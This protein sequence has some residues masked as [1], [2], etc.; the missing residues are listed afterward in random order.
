MSSTVQRIPAVIV[1]GG[2]A[3]IA[4]AAC[5]KRR[6]LDPVVLEKGDTVAPAWRRHYERLHLHTTRR[7]SGLP[8]RPM[9]ADYPKYPSRDQVFAYL[10]RYAREEGLEVRTGVEVARCHRDDGHWVVETTYGDRFEAPHLVIATGLSDVPRVPG[11][12]NQAAYTGEILHSAEYRNGGPY[13]GRRVLVVGFGNSAAEIALDLFEHGAS[14]HVSVR[15][16]TV[17]V[18]RDVAGIIPVLSLG[19]FLS[20]LPPRLADRL[21]RPLRRITVGDISKL[22]IPAADWGPMEQIARKRKVP[23]LDVGTLAALRRGDVHAHPGVKAFTADGVVFTDGSSEPFDAVVL[24]TGF[25][26][27]VDRILETTAAVLDDSGRPLVSGAAT[28]EP[29]LYFCGFQEA[30]TGRLQRIGMEAG[31]LAELI[32]GR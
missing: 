5:L 11:F 26:P 28:A 6:G 23:V 14:S 10:D 32:A 20:K 19:R 1:G 18:P 16:P 7:A 24:G 4:T 30:P 13:A 22:G 29:G 2:P 31:R 17:V 27:G 21:S 3:G 8:G 9:P 15:S 25:Q 12:A